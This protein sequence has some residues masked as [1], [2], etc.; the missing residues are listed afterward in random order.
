FR[1]SAFEE[2][3][4]IRHIE[5]ALAFQLELHRLSNFHIKP[6]FTENR[7]IHVYQAVGKEVA[8]DKRYFTRAV[9]RPGRLR[10]E[11]PTAEYLISESDR[12]VNDI[13]DAMEIIGNNNSDMNHIFINFSQV[14]PLVPEEVESALGGF[15]ERFGR[16]FWRLRVTGAEIRIVCT[17]PTTGIT[18]PLRVFINNVSG[19]VITVELY[20]EKKNDKGQLIFASIG[21]KMGAMHLRP[22]STPYAAKEWLQP[23]R[24]KAH[25]MEIGRASCRERVWIVKAHVTD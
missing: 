9:V 24:Y 8:S 7:N 20:T 2:D 1:G 6:V 4:S 14:F 21:P 25:L 17:D 15:I 18:H 10:D 12:L 22:V 16:R 11:I 13:L 3:K 5:P 23:K 19:Y